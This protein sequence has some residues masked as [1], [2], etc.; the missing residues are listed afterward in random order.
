MAVT[1]IAPVVFSDCGVNSGVA[2]AGARIIVGLPLAFIGDV[3]CNR[4]MAW[5]PQQV[6]LVFQHPYCE[7]LPPFVSSSDFAFTFY[8]KLVFCKESFD[9]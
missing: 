3:A 8:P 7:L 1:T 6:A 2:L 4:L 9:R 5:P